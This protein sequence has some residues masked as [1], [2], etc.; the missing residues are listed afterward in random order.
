MKKNWIGLGAFACVS[1][2]LAGCGESE[3]TLNYKLSAP[4]TMELYAESYFAT[5]D[6]N[7]EEQMGTI[8]AA[9]ADLEYSSAGDTT[10]VR[11]T[12]TIDKSRGYLKNYMPSELAWRIKEVDIAAVDRDVVSLTGLEDGYD[13]LLSKIPMPERWRKQLLNPDY[14]PHLKRLEKH[15]WEM[16][17][18]LTGTV[19][20]KANIT[21]MLKD[22]GRLNFALI[23]IDS[24]VT[25]GFENRDH[26]KCLDYIVYLHETESFPYYIWEQHVNS[27]IIPEKYKAY[28]AG[29]KAEYD[30]QFEVML[31]PTTG[32]PCQEREVKVGT[33][34]MVHPVTKDTVK[35]TSH[36]TNE[37][38]YNTKVAEET[39]E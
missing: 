3:V 13:S 34:T 39:A 38:L 35:F 14:K 16:D 18:L 20:V 24:V 15:R 23:A 4:V 36:I 29:H 37:R 22:Q 21:Q 7:G 5:I 26:R 10:K 30:T 11:R 17:H 1:F 32:V 25:K 27:N 6:L 8:T 19:P 31:D 9:Y 2:L 28:T 33:H 12:Y